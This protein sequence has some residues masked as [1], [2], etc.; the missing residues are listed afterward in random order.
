MSREKRPPVAVACLHCKKKY[1][2]KNQHPLVS[3]SL[4]FFSAS[5]VVFFLFF[6]VFFF[7]SLTT[8][9]SVHSQNNMSSKNSRKRSRSEEEVASQQTAAIAAFVEC[10]SFA[11]FFVGRDWSSCWR[12]CHSQ[13]LFPSS[14]SSTHSSAVLFF[15]H[16]TI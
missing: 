5:F 16:S 3:H 1:K 9:M 12:H 10:V 7:C 4:F 2:R 13:S 6:V 15:S 11:F 8:D 14:S